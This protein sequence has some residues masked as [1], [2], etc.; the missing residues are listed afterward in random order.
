MPVTAER[1]PPAETPVRTQEPVAVMLLGQVEQPPALVAA[2][3]PEQVER[4]PALVAR[5]QAPVVVILQGQAA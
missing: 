3:L 4:S 2:M 1:Q 5:S